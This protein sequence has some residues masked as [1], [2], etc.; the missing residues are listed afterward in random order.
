MWMV[1][2]GWPL[3]YFPVLYLH[4][5]QQTAV[6]TIY[7]ENSNNRKAAKSINDLRYNKCTHPLKYIMRAV[8]S[9][10]Y[11]PYVTL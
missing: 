10:F 8:Y 7:F 2:P 3:H 6:S 11:L 5:G 1:L 9:I 4:I